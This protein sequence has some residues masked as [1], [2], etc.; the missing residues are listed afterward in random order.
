[1]L[2][3]TDLPHPFGLT[4]YED[5][6]YWTDWQSKS[7]ESADRKTG[8]ERKTVREN[9]ENLMDIHVFHRQRPKGIKPPPMMYP[10]TG[11][12]LSLDMLKAQVGLIYKSTNKM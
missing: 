10:A 9:L 3:G 4:L 5:R 11:T 8:L 6:I 7:I 1:M 12:V 2:I